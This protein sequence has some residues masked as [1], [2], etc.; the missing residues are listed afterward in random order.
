MKDLKVITYDETNTRTVKKTDAVVDSVIDDF[1]ERA[2]FGK[3]KYGKD[4]DRD[5][6]S[7]CDWCEHAI[8]EAMDMILYL[9]KIQ[10]TICNGSKK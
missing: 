4:L 10:K 3:K 5:D 7:L 6:L 2:W 9:R 8:Q 1:I